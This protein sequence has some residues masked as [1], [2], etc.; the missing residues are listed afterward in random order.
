MTFTTYEQAE[1]HR[2][3][4]QVGSRDIHYVVAKIFGTYSYRVDAY[5]MTYSQFAAASKT[6]RAA[7]LI[8]P[9]Y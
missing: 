1:K 4:N 2:V 9:L 8:P 3:F 6:E 7:A 5:R